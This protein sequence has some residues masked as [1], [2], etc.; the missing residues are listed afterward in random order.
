M[1]LRASG[2]CPLCEKVTAD[3]VVDHH[4]QSGT[5]RGLI[6]GP[7]NFHLAYLERHGHAAQWMLRA[8]IYLRNGA[9]KA[10]RL[11]GSAGA[12]R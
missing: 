2:R 5:V 3:L 11:S 1:V 6:C 4:H 7:C 8:Q 12:A 10:R 9:A